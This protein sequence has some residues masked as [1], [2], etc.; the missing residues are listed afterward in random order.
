MNSDTKQIRDIGTY[1]MEEKNLNIE[2]ASQLFNVK[3]I[4]WRFEW[5]DYKKF[6]GLIF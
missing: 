5:K 1:D 6:K 4:H 3:S 2:T